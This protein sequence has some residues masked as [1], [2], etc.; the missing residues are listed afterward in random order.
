MATLSEWSPYD[1]YVQAGMVD[2]RYMNAAYTLLAAGPPRLA[3]I[4]GPSFFGASLASNSRSSDQIAYPLG[5]IQQFQLGNNTQLARFFEIGSERSY[6]IPGRT[7]GSLSLARVMYHGASLL[8][9]L[10]AYY[11][12][13]IPPTTVPSVFPNLGSATVGNPHDVVI[14]PGYEN[15]YLNLAS[16]LFKQPIGLLLLFKD[17]NQDTLGAYY[18]EDCHVPQH[19]LSMDAMGT[20]LQEGVGIQFERMLP[21]ATRVVGLVTGLETPSLAPNPTL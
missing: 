6:F 21:I 4:G 2:G 12:D 1:K 17:S 15:I 18:F 19:S 14:P 13:L 8:R 7:M 11:Q 9:V 16:D 3:N 20:V 10:Y 5:L